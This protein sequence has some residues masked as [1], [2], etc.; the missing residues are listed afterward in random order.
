MAFAVPL[1]VIGVAQP[2]SIPASILSLH[3]A[4]LGRATTSG[5][6]ATATARSAAARAAT[7]WAMFG[8]Y[9][10]NNIGIAFQ[11]FA[12]GLFFG[13][14][15]LFVL[16]FNGALAGS[17]AGYLTWRGLG[18]NFYSVRRSRTAPSS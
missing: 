16:A 17:V 14:G 13:I 3:D 9:I 6:T 11:C 1:L 18:E 4:G 8:H 2:I 12:G 7:D 15:S 5:C 10:R